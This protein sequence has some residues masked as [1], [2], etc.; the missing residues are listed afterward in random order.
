MPICL[1]QELPLLLR[2]A[3]AVA[4]LSGPTNILRF[5]AG[6]A[7][8]LTV[9]GVVCLPTLF[10]RCAPRGRLGYAAMAIG[11]DPGLVGGGLLLLSES[12]S[13]P[14]LSLDPFRV[15]FVITLG[16][17]LVGLWIS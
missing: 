7:M 11:F 13:L 17:S 15:L 10:I 4:D 9:D 6:F 1:F 5:R 12:I 2:V 8:T 16:G 14:P 3:S